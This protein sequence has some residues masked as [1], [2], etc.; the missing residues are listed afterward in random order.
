MK[1]IN[2][3]KLSVV[4]VVHQAIPVGPSYDLKKFFIKHKV[5]ELLFITHPLI[6]LKEFYK[7][8]SSYFLYKNGDKI[9]S[10]TAFH[11]VMPNTFLYIKDFVYSI[12]WVYLQKKKFSI[13]VGAD[14]LNALA[15]LFLKKIGRVEKVVYYAIDY[16]PK[17]F[18]NPILNWIYHFIDK[19]SVRYSDEIWNLSETM[20]IARK[21]GKKKQFVVPVGVWFD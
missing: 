11:W 3:G 16:F 12:I 9:E 17:R 20:I 4:I 8:S 2:F 18:K 21:M 5:N 6:Y 13:F 15:G 10:K 7:D 19:L 14:P 1:N